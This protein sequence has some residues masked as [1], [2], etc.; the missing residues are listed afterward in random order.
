LASDAPI[1]IVGSARPEL[2]DERPDWGVD[3]PEV[4][5]MTLEPLDEDECGRLIRNLLGGAGV[6]TQT[7]AGIARLL[8]ATRCSSKSS[9][10]S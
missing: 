5:A 6:P 10:R 2:L 1:L 7:A 3:S 9:S 8:A 4:A